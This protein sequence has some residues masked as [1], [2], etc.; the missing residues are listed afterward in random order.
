V[1]RIDHIDEETYLCPS[2]TN[3]VR[4]LRAVNTDEKW[5]IVVNNIKVDYEE[6][7]QT[8]RVEEC[9]T[10]GEHCPIVTPCYDSKCVQ[11]S[12]IHRFLIYDPYDQYFPFAIETFKLPASC[13]CYV[14]AY[15][16]E[17]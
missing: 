15:Y 6:Y 3:Y 2:E 4:P 12:I 13:A 1:D 5:R 7:T 14:G 11:K 10:P 9:L 17:H 8:C 16:L